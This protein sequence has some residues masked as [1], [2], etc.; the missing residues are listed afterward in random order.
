MSQL[1]ARLAICSVACP[2]VLDC[3][4]PLAWVPSNTVTLAS[5]VQELS[6]ALA[7]AK[8]RTR[9][10]PS[11]VARAA[12]N[13]Y[14]VLGLP[15]SASKDEAKKLFRGRALKE[16]PDVNPDDAEAEER[17]RM[18]VNAYNSI[19]GDEI[20]PDELLEIRVAATKAYQEKMKDELKAGA[21]LVFQGNARLVQGVVQIAFFAG[22]L[23]LANN[24]DVVNSLF[25]PPIRNGF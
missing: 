6:P 18:L 9:R 3:V 16:H 19:M 2:L 24:P 10:L 23:A 4:G 14:D 8:L 21:D 13:P 22:V 15:R 5:P 1:L 12:Q 7:G 20:M 25:A 17:F 11:V